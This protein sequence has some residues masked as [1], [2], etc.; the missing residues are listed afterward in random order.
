MYYPTSFKRIPVS[1]CVI[2]ILDIRTGMF[3]YLSNNTLECFGYHY[4]YFVDSGYR[5]IEKNKHQEDKNGSLRKLLCE[6]GRYY[7]AAL[8]QENFSL[9]EEY[10][11]IKADQHIVKIREHSMVYKKNPTGGITHLIGSSMC[12]SENRNSLRKYVPANVTD[13][14]DEN[15]CHLSNRELEI[16][17]LISEGKNSKTIAEQLFISYHTVTTHRKK[18]NEKMKV[19]NSGEL[20]RYAICNGLI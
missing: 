16:V 9:T 15:N 7:T 19:R 14:M 4:Q 13:T 3:S 17:K 18:I 20:I 2:W 8:F 12:I 6:R 1:S 5:F 11:I 10:R